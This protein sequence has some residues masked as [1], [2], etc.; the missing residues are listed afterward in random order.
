MGG[1]PD[2]MPGVALHKIFNLVE[3]QLMRLTGVQRHTMVYSQGNITLFE[4]K[5]EIIQIFFA[6][7]PGG[8]DYR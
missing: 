2:N 7:P 4:V 5:D 6:R 3:L 8:N 1:K